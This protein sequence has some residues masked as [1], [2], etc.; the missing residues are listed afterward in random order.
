MLQKFTSEYDV[1]VLDVFESEKLSKTFY[2]LLLADKQFSRHDDYILFYSFEEVSSLYIDP[3]FDFHNM[4]RDENGVFWLSTCKTPL[5]VSDITTAVVDL[6]RPVTI[7]EFLC[8]IIQNNLLLRIDGEDVSSRNIV[9]SMSSDDILL[10][11][12][13]SGSYNLIWTTPDIMLVKNITPLTLICDKAFYDKW[14]PFISTSGVIKESADSVVWELNTWELKC[15]YNGPYLSCRFCDQELMYLAERFLMLKAHMHGVELGHWFMRKLNN[16][17]STLLQFNVPSI[18]RGSSAIKFTFDV[19]FPVA[20]TFAGKLLVD[21]DASYKAILNAG[22][23]DSVLHYLCDDLDVNINNYYTEFVRG[24]LSQISCNRQV[25]L[26]HEFLI[27]EH[28]QNEITA[29]ACK[30]FAYR[31]V[32]L[33][34]ITQSEPECL[35]INGGV[36]RME[37]TE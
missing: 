1:Y 19:D 13:T 21:L 14:E 24:F 18:A 2:K 37:V 30:I 31:F 22:S 28:T 36:L 17:D 9:F 16:I 10:V 34:T 7:W 15:Q 35:Y 29:L 26:D 5:P 32:K 12:P 33:Q 8:D 3:R 20:S 4:V 25:I 6:A 27:A 11:N 23:V